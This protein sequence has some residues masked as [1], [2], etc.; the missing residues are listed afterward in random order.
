MVDPYLCLLGKPLAEAR[1]EVI[2]AS[3]FFE[4]YASQA[5]LIP[6]EMLCSPL[7]GIELSLSYLYSRRALN[8]LAISGT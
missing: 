6:G 3:D 7:K 2:Y 1:G 8:L 4:V 5:R